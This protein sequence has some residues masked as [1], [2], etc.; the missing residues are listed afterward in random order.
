MIKKYKIEN[1]KPT[2]LRIWQKIN[3]G[4]EILPPEFF[5]EN[6]IADSGY[7][8]RLSV[9]QYDPNT[10]FFYLKTI[11]YSVTSDEQIY[12]YLDTGRAVSVYSSNHYNRIDSFYIYNDLIIA[13]KEII[14]FEGYND[15][16]NLDLKVLGEI[17]NQMV[18]VIFNEDLTKIKSRLAEIRTQEEQIRLSESTEEI[19]NTQEQ[20]KLISLIRQYD[21]MTLLEDTGAIIKDNYFIDKQN[22]F[23][24]E[25]KDKVVN[26][27]EKDDL[28]LEPNSY[29]GSNFINIDFPHFLHI[30]EKIYQ[31][32][33]YEEDFIK[34][35]KHINKKIFHFKIYSYDTETKAEV[36]LKTIKIEN[37]VNEKG[38][39]RFKINGIKIPIQK[40]SRAIGFIRPQSDKNATIEKIT[41]LEK[42]LE[43]I[44]LYSGTQLELLSG[45][46]IEIRLNGITIPIHF[47]IMAE[48]KDNWHISIDDFSI[49]KNYTSVKDAFHYLSGGG[50]SAISKICDTLQAGEKLEN[51]LIGRVKGFVEKRKL[52]EER[53]ENLF[54]EFLEK[55]K[56]KVFKKE[57]GYIVKGKLKNYI[58]K[59]KDEDNVGVW[60]YPGNDYICI[61]ERTKNGNYLCKHDKLLQFCIT[62][63][64]DNLMREEIHTIR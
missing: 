20:E 48:D 45:K 29:S 21:K 23:K 39:L 34:K 27:F 56:T 1:T 5:G 58:V 14:D 41:N 28:V 30:L 3:F 4:K 62:M 55:N 7:S 51:I 8:Y 46:T 13:D 60:S 33:K 16:K 36:F 19:N 54:I 22:G 53:A 52:A 61:N 24:V 43:Q 57:G 25:F 42:Y 49:R 47:N 37:N 38:K 32:G 12:N 59:M 6:D 18:Y 26:L 2:F 31:Q 10:R 35:A 15:K 63:L 11:L 40:M 50:L 44:R 9:Y 64:N 17:D